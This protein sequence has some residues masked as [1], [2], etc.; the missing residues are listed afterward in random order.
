MLLSFI[1]V[2]GND[3]DSH[4]IISVGFENHV[5]LYKHS[6]TKAGKQTSKMRTNIRFFCFLEEIGYFKLV[7]PYFFL[8]YP[9]FCN[10]SS[11]F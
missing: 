11:T 4:Q 7:F 3:D 5:F 6:T 1:Q 10:L 2:C 8:F 9:P